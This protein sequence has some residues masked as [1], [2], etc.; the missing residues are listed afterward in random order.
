MGRPYKNAI[1]QITMIHHAITHID[2]RAAPVMDI[3]IL[4]TIYRAPTT[5][6]HACNPTHPLKIQTPHEQ[7]LSIGSRISSIGFVITLR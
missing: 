7:S 1:L 3:G 5:P 2:P 4:G 6:R